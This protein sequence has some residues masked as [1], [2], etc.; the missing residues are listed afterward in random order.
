MKGL[1]KYGIDNGLG[2]K[3]KKVV[4]RFLSSEVD[5]NKCKLYSPINTYRSY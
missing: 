3:R 4:E 5:S 2:Q 1:Y